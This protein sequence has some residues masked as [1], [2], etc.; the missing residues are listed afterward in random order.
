MRVFVALVALALVS[1]GASAAEAGRDMTREVLIERELQRVDASLVETFR[2]ARVAM[3]RGDYAEA[4]T[5]YAKVHAA[6][7]TFDPAIRRLGTSLVALGKRTE[8]LRLCEKAVALRRS[9]ENL[10]TLAYN[11]G[12]STSGG[13]GSAAEK[14][15]ALQ[16]LAEA[17]ALPGG[18][19]VDTLSVTA[20]LAFQLD[21]PAMARSAVEELRA[22]HPDHMVTRY[23]S[24]LVHAI[25][26][27]WIS[28]EREI[29]VA[30]RLGLPAERV[31]SFLDSGVSTRATAWRIAL[32]AGIGVGGWIM[33]LLSLFALGFVLSRVVLR[34][35][36]HADAR[37]AV[38]L[39]ER[40][41]R[42][43][44]RAVINVAGVYYY[45]SLP[46]VMVIIVGTSCAIFYG[47]FTIGRVPIKLVAIVG[48]IA[49]VTIW[50]MLRSLFIRVSSEEPGRALLR[51]EA[52]GL[53]KLTDGVARALGTPAIDEIRITPGTELAVYERGTWREKLR[54]EAK[55]VLILGTGVL[56][57]F[58]QDD[59]RSVLAHEYG[60]FSNRDT[61]GGDIALRVRNDM[62][63]LYVAMCEAGQASAF[64]VAF[65]F[66]RVYHFI[67]RRI[68][69]GATRLQEILADRFAAR[70]YGAQALEGGL[71]HVIRRSIEF[72]AV[73]EREIKAGIEARRP[74]QNLYDAGVTST[75]DIET[76]FQNVLKEKTSP[77][78]THPSPADR[79]RLVAHLN[80]PIWEPCRGDVWDLFSDRDAITREM[81]MMLE[82]QIAR[83]RGHEADPADAPV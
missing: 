34:H 4:S 26:E 82:E 19:D 32:Y 43:V 2:R 57:G 18:D 37:L 5:G 76:A 79:I 21:Q 60:H 3:D 35:A 54:N 83:L 29:R 12:V 75:A 50:A 17:R 27:E 38:S 66:L 42:R 8:G 62:M 78:D 70:A 7:P 71:H 69:H 51:D 56:P 47:F 65:Q 44:Y 53:W 64:N 68:S 10:S 9:P 58:K 24:A 23:L 74:L 80:Q 1:G 11:L 49:V 72:H 52:E 41:L 63:K 59:F 28:A 39:T 36:E 77:D 6:A 46:V 15:R 61:A 14:G 55:R 30:E 20:Q 40:R 25:D 31:K 48:V 45:I 73:A 67:F 33:G 22:K 13:A 81:M 16:L